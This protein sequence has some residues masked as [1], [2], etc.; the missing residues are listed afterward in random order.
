MDPAFQSNCGTVLSVVLRGALN[1]PPDSTV[2][3]P[4]MT[5]APLL[6][7]P[8][9][10]KSMAPPSATVTWPVISAC[11]LAVLGILSVT[12]SPILS[13]LP[14][15]TT[16]SSSVITVIGDPESLVS[17]TDEELFNKLFTVEVETVP[18]VTGSSLAATAQEPVALHSETNGFSALFGPVFAFS[19][20]WSPGIS[21][22]KQI[23]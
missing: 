18:P 22:L 17:V 6:L 20:S 12:S 8:I 15:G 1:I 19:T 5:I 4:F 11:Q 13:S 9:S 16:N 21:A 14:E 2:I 23:I 10:L 7:V 3:V